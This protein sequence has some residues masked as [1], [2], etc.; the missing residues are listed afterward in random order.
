[1]LYISESRV[2]AEG[3]GYNPLLLLYLVEQS[4][5]SAILKREL[6]IAVKHEDSE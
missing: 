5:L 3:F 4:L 6:R 1:M 2:R